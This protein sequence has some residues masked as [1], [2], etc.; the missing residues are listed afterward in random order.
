[1]KLIAR[2][3]LSLA[4]AAAPASIAAA[5][6]YDPPI[7]VE[8][9]L[10]VP[11]EIGSGWY[12]RGDVG[13]AV[14]TDIGEVSNRAFDP[15]SSTYGREAFATHSLDRNITWGGGFGYSL[16]EWLRA[17]LTAD[18]FRTSFDGT[19]A[20]PTPCINPG[21]GGTGCRSENAAEMSAISVMANAYVDLGI[22]IG[23][24]PYVGAG[25]GYSFVSWGGLHDRVYC[26]DGIGQCP[27]P[28]G[29]LWSTNHDGE[30]GWR[31]TYALMAGVAY[32]L[33]RNFKLDLGYKYR[34]IEGGDMFR[35]DEATA[36]L[37][38][39]GAQG[40]HGDIDQHEV[41]VGLRYEI[42]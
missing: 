38:A 3:A 42:W 14:Q 15:L 1:M 22:V 11:V 35:W 9:A 4:A 10:E 16:N 34:R 28:V 41:R 12:L 36:A 23:F 21:F 26:T 37:G 32:D 13:Y 20:S 17:D 7:Y 8:D 30:D 40:S 2:I 29:E 19:T 31:F 39:T 6:D 24:T 33:T 18:G 27:L 25:A 5:A